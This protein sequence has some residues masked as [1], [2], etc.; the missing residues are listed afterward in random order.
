MWA[1][2]LLAATCLLLVLRTAL[3]IR[4]HIPINW[5]EGWNA[6]H[7]TDLV[8]GRPLYRGST[9]FFF[10]NYPPLSFY[11][12]AAWGWLLGDQMLAGR[13]LSLLALIGWA[14]LL[15][16][17][18][19]RLGCRWSEAAFAALLLLASLFLFNV[20]NVGVNDPEFLG[21]VLQA[22]GLFIL[23]RE[24]RTPWS[25][26]SCAVLF[27]AGVFVKHLLI[28]LPIA[29]VVWLMVFDRRAAWRLM[30]VGSLLA[31]AGLAASV[32]MFGPDFLIQL[33]SPR[34]YLPAR[35]AAMSAEWVSRVLGLVLVSAVLA[36]RYLRDPRVALALLYAGLATVLG[37]A[38]FGGDGVYWNNMFD[39]EWA[40]CL[41][42]ALALNRLPAATIERDTDHRVRL[43]L[44]TACLAVP[45]AMTAMGA[46]IHWGSPRYWLD[47]R[48]FE[49]ETAAS[50][51]AFIRSQP[52]P[53]LCEQLSLCFWAG[54]PVEADFFGLHQRVR[55][56]PSRADEL[57][58][59]VE[60][61]RFAVAQLD[62]P[63]QYLGPRFEEAMRQNYRI[64]H[65]NEWGVFWVPK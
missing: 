60:A 25:L 16:L 35:A 47:P 53:V 8:M 62:I 50:E 18:A 58:R 13:S 31:V 24:P 30:A 5:N 59:Q 61:R 11:I 26:V 12:V 10:N 7:T 1:A 21:H 63:T 43:G 40:L 22:L 45:V 9:G 48:W 15:A 23:L 49:A 4:L 2:L 17:T 3:I 52:G 44:V 51:I 38:L 36:R 56:D 42:A 64:D 32:A 54:K 20:F 34:A 28:A 14:W 29:A 46:Q 41:T 6:Y 27:A 55:R 39:A 57:A 65:Q 37:L 19:K 33:L